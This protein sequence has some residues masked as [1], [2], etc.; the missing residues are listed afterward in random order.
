MIVGT[1]AGRNGGRI[2]GPGKFKGDRDGLASAKLVRKPSMERC[3][4]AADH[5][6]V[7]KVEMAGEPASAVVVTLFGENDLVDEPTD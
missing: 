7:V 4:L 6:P 1:S 3:S 2:R 5:G